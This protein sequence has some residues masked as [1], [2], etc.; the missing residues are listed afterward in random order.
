MEASYL[1]RELEALA[2]HQKCI[3]SGSHSGLDDG[4]VRILGLKA[5]R[6]G[7]YSSISLISNRDYVK[8]QKWKASW[9]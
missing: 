6:L 1:I 8:W 3:K 2:A 5:S 4:K 7:Y 9:S